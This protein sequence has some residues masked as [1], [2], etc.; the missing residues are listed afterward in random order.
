MQR[1]SEANLDQL[2]KFGSKRDFLQQINSDVY[3]KPHS[4][5]S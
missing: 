4:V 2:S 3:T 1:K 5:K